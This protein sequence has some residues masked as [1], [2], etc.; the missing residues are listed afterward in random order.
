MILCLA[1]GCT[2]AGRWLRQQLPQPPAPHQP[3]LRPHAHHRPSLTMGRPRLAA[4]V[5]PLG[6]RTIL[7]GPGS[8]PLELAVPSAP[9]NAGAS[10]TTPSLAQSRSDRPRLIEAP[11]PEPVPVQAAAAQASAEPNFPPGAP[12]A[13]EASRSPLRRRSPA[14]PAAELA[15]PCSPART[16]PAASSPPPARNSPAKTSSNNTAARSRGGSRPALAR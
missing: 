10:S 2:Y 14:T 3:R 16:P 4:P 6:A 8:S 9:K 1:H 12:A 7:A 5:A 13:P 11:V 15:A